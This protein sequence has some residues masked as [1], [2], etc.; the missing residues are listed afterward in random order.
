MNKFISIIIPIRNE[1]NY[2]KG[3]LES[4]LN[5]DYP[6]EYLEILFIDGMSEDKTIE[7][8]NKYQKKFPYIKILQNKEKIVPI[9]MNIGIKESKGDYICRL[10]AHAKYPKN[11]I[12][13]LFEWSQELDADNV[14]AVC[15]TNI[16]SKTNTAKA[17]QFV[18]SD[19]FGVGNSLFRI[20]V[21]EP[22]EVDT[23]PFGFYKKEVFDKIGFYDERLVRTQDLE[24]N[25][26]LKKY[27]GKIYLIPDVQCT[28]YPREDYKSFFKNRFETGRWVMLSSYFT[29]SLNS[30]SIRHI[31]P[32]FFSLSLI[33]S[34]LLV[35]FE[36]QFIYIFGFI[37]VG[38]FLILFFRALKIKKNFSLA[39]NILIG[40]FVLHFSYGL[41]SL[42]GLLE[43]I[44]RKIKTI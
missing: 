37:L 12:S 9:A 10:D 16:K 20:G 15:I 38:Y 22:L 8:L 31:V 7:I 35:F 24:L 39:F 43:I 19:K 25:K 36:K 13:K 41:G 21:E 29:N 27:N 6:K 2:I 28:Y 42:K 44:K 3:C 26:R 33:L 4:I 18:M 11:Y 30:I 34:F 14:G 5:F 40:Y 1:E 17:I 32:L 23:V